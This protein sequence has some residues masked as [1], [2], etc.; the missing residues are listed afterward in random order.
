MDID[1]WFDIFMDTLRKLG[2]RGPVD[3]DSFVEDWERDASPEKTAKEFF[4]EISG[5]N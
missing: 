1:D 4:K 5:P 3:K 2:Y